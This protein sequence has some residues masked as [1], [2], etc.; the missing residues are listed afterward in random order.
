MLINPEVVGEDFVW[1]K[2]D[3]AKIWSFGPNTNGPNMLVD[4]AKGVQF[5]N[6]INARA[7]SVTFRNT[8]E[9][10]YIHEG[11]SKFR[12]DIEMVLIEKRTVSYLGYRGC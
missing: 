12:F 1:E 8:I 11:R 5:L 2:D 4:V 6:E 9:V 3:T 10:S 7:L